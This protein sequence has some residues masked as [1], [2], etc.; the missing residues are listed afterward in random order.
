MKFGLAALAVF[1]SLNIASANVAGT[2]GVGSSGFVD[3]T[4]DSLVWSPDSAALP[5]PGPPWNGDVNSATN[6]TFTGCTSGVLNSPGCLILQ[7]GILINNGNAFCGGFNPTVCS[8][9]A[10]TLP[11]QTFLQF[12]LHPNL[13]YELDGVGAGSSNDCFVNPTITCSI[14]V[15]GVGSPVTLT[16]NGTGGTFVGIG[17]F[18]KASDTGVAGLSSPNASFWQGGFSATIPNMTPAQIEAFFCDGHACTTADILAGKTLQVDSVSGSF[19]ATIVPEP[20]TVS[21]FLIGGALIGLS[22]FRRRG[23]QA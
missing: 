17:F 4:L 7:E 9:G 10:T 20:G 11:V 8:G 18:G 5:A 16:P 3:A 1:L 12:E 13:V 23:A 6:V 19:S 2:L 22:W 14:F 15:N 21:L